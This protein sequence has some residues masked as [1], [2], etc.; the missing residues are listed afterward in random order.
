MG[1]EI[2]LPCGYLTAGGVLCCELV[3]C[4]TQVNMTD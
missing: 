4:G 2:V 1:L 3:S